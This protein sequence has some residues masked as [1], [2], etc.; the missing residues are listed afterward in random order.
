MLALLQRVTQAHV[1]VDGAVAGAIDAGL[2]VL[3]N[4]ERGD[5]PERAEK[6]AERLVKLRLFANGD[7][8]SFDRSLHDTR[9]SVLVISQFTLSADLDHGL[10]PSF[11]DAAPPEEAEPLYRAFV[12]ALRTRSIPVATGVFGAMMQVSLTNDGPATFLLRA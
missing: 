3:L 10:R 4:I 7:G 8:K 11:S 5:T 2:V 1:T 6:L 9:G 12:D